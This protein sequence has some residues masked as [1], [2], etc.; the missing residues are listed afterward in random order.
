MTAHTLEGLGIPTVVVGSARD[1]VEEVGVPRFVF[2]NVP[3]GNPFGP[4][5][6][7][8][9]Q[10]AVLG[11]A[12]D[13]LEAA[14]EPRTTVEA[15]VRWTGVED[16]RDTYMHVGDDNRAELAEAGRQRRAEQASRRKG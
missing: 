2:T 14:W 13:L 3:L 4:P 12:L 6:D 7:T 1:I 16:W 10:K 15:D 9:T 5:H 8:T 11:K